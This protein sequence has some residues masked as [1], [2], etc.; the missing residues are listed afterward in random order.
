MLR[1][2]EDNDFHEE[3]CVV[4]TVYLNW[5]ALLP[6]VKLNIWGGLGLYSF[7]NPTVLVLELALLIPCYLFLLP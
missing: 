7:V 1:L 6:L 4:T 3:C 5:R 2:P